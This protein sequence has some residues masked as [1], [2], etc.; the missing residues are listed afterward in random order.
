MA[1]TQTAVPARS[2]RGDASA[3]GARAPLVR[4]WTATLS[5]IVVDERDAVVPDA[6]VS[7]RDTSEDLQRQ[8]T[9]SRDGDFTIPLL[10][11]GSYIVRA[12]R[13]GFRTAEI[14]DLV[15]NSDEQLTI[16]IQLK[17][18]NFGEKVV[19][20][21]ETSALPKSPATS[22]TFDRHLVENLPLNGRSIQPTLALSPGTVPT[23]ATFD[24]Q[25]QFSVN[26]QRANTNYFVIDGVSANIGVAAGANLGQ[27]GSGSLPGLDV[28]GG[29]SNLVGVEALQELKIHSSV[30]AA[31]YGR[32]P[33]AQVSIVTRAGSNG[34]RGTLF[35]H[36]RHGALGAKDWFANRESLAPPPLRL[37]D[38]GAALG[39]PIVRD[40]TFFF[41]SYEGMQLRRPRIAVTDVP[42][43]AAR[44]AAPTGMRPFLDAFPVPN[45]LDTHGGLAEFSAAYTDALRLHAASLRLDHSLGAKLTI[46]G[47]FN[48]SPSAAVERGA[49]ASLNTVQRTS[50]TT[51]TLTVGA[52]HIVTPRIANDVRFNHSRSGARRYS[53][54]DAFGGAV[55]PGDTL[56]FPASASPGESRYGFVIGA[57]PSFFAGKIVDNVQRQINVVD[58]LSVVRGV[59]QMKFGADYRR[60]NP[61]YG[62]RDLSYVATFTDVAEAVAGRASSVSIYDYIPAGIVFTNFSLYAQDT[63]RA[64]RRLTLVYGLRWEYNPAP[65]GDDGQ[66]M[67]AVSGL[68]NPPA[69]AIA[70][71]GTPLYRNS[72]DNFAPRLSV[73]YELSERP[74][75]GS[76]LRGGF[77]IFYDLG[78]GQ[79]A[80][81]TSTYPYAR[82]KILSG[83][84]YPLD[85]AA[86]TLR[87][88]APY[89]PIAL[90]RA[91]D[92]ELKTPRTTQWNIGV[93]QS[94]GDDQTVSAS[95]VAA[96]GRR[97]LRVEALNN[98]NPRFS[99]VLVTTNSASSDYHS[100]QLQFQR[101]LSRGL[102]A[103][104][105]YTWS[106]S[107]DNASNDSTLHPPSALID[108]RLDRG[109][110]D[111]DVRHSLSA[112]VSYNLPRL[113]ATKG[114]SDALIRG[115]SLDT[116]VTARTAP[117]VEVFA[118][119]DFG[120]GLFAFRP[121]VIAGVPVYLDDASAPGGRVI[122]RA[123]FVVPVAL[124][125][126]ALGRNALRGFPASQVDFALRRQFLLT[127]RF[128]LLLRAEFFNLLNHP[129][130]GDPLGDLGSGFFGRST[131]M[132]GESLGSGVGNGGY[133]S[134]FQTGGPRAIQLALKLQF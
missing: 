71:E 19:V 121:D 122:N 123:A 21:A 12:E 26:G 134:V 117:P 43:I 52:T 101:R 10:P 111:F 102:Q 76:V 57:G 65:A 114:I 100:L 2:A 77:G 75:W 59:H 14:T 36:F 50:F 23:K 33:G 42:S 118:S 105:A 8:A 128:G 61:T 11:P 64:G 51:R 97:L 79:A 38:F 4:P 80:G 37:H 3:S 90:T 40:R 49:G 25:G 125:Q 124:R 5:G 66:H 47:R 68:E 63:W 60:L 132:L 13:Q 53:Q 39:G 103:L 126:G 54:L 24:A 30:Y 87:P 110:S 27:S 85:A 116:I 9:T 109:P 16:K 62:P 7:V 133:N 56:L 28:F 15:L 106:H 6:S 93:E 115:W 74:R 20:E 44:Q 1:A 70:P 78:S 82:G 17:V 131:S 130:F 92:P 69:L 86:A 73:A 46:F 91:F 41:L 22:T 98:P 99:Q 95:Y 119:R 104:A 72:F 113:S 96:M 18:G 32:L 94:L 81:A 84:A 88:G 58:N 83:A 108:P 55:P 35:E 45:R 129:N 112:A 89:Y 107:T 29:A 127:E 48:Y 67:L 120:F 31:E 34:W